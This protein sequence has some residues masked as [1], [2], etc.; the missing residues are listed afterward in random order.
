MCIPD[1]DPA[2]I[3]AL[4][5]SPGVELGRWGSPEGQ[6]WPQRLKSFLLWAWG[7]QCLLPVLGS[8]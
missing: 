8:Q 1:Q 7:A 6:A 4:C 2:Q 3:S 5:F